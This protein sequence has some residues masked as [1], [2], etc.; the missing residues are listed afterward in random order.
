MVKHAPFSQRLI[1]WKTN[2]TFVKWGFFIGCEV[3]HKYIVT[4]LVSSVR[5]SVT[6]NEGN[7]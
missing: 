5:V 3:V 6:V 4:L 2:E 7:N 1:G